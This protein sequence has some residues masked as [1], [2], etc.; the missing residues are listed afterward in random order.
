M[1]K[2]LLHNPNDYGTTALFKNPILEKLA[3]T[4]IAVPLSIYFVGSAWLI[5]ISFS[6]GYTGLWEGVGVFVAG[7]I[8]WTFTEYQMHK[9]VFHMLPTNKFKEK[10]QY[11]FHGVHHEFPRDKTRLAMPPAA[12]L[13]ILTAL[14]FIFKLI[15]GNYAYTFLP[16]FVMGYSA[17]LGVHYMVHAFRPPKNRFNVLWIN[18]SIHHYKDD[19]VAFGVSSPLWDYLIGTMPKK[20]YKRKP[21]TGKRTPADTLEALVS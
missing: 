8:F 3:R 13:M 7:M 15:I 20:T 12:S 18:H 11:T 10:L 5:Y 17:Y 21:G 2:Q 14:F 6:K 19:T 4:H 1:E 9:H 16:G